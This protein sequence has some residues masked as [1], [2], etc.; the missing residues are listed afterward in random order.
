[1]ST[2][3]N[4]DL[5]D[6]PSAPEDESQESP[7]VA[8]VPVKGRKSRVRGSVPPPKPKGKGKPAARARP[9]PAPEPEPEP[10]PAPVAPAPVAP[11]GKGKAA[12]G[13]FSSP[14]DGR[15]LRFPAGASADGVKITRLTLTPSNQLKLCGDAIR[16][17]VML[18]LHINGEMTVN[19][20]CK[21]LDNISQ[22]AVSH[23]LAL[24]RHSRLIEP[25]RSGKHNFYELSETGFKLAEVLTQLM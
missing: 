14:V 7:S 18:F 12:P 17:A 16:A 19:E 2:G 8:G 6:N 11:K 10:A 3:T 13:T 9:E 25:R 23:H 22:P 21:G 5:I 20:L 15:V 1:M 4:A 24:L